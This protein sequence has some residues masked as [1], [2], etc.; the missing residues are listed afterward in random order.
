LSQTAAREDND[1]VIFRE[2]LLPKPSLVLSSIDGRGSQ[3]SEL[4][5]WQTDKTKTLLS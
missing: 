5:S 3:L 1:Q 4:S 2:E